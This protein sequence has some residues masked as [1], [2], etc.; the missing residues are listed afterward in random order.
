MDSLS[1]LI[2]CDGC[3]SDFDHGPHQPKILPKCG[4]T[5][6]MRCIIQSQVKS[7][8]AKDLNCIL[9]GTRQAIDNGQPETLL[10]NDKVLKIVDMVMMA[11]QHLDKPYYQLAQDNHDGDHM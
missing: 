11:S 8:N 10:T 2:K 9:C 7:G 5:L 4:E 1:S 3:G 6:C